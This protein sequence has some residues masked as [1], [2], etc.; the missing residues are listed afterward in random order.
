MSMETLTSAADRGGLRELTDDE[1]LARFRAFPPGSQ[2][3]AA[4]C[5]ILVERYQKLVRACV[6]QYAGSPEPVEDLLQ[7][8]VF[9]QTQG[10]GEPRLPV[11]G[12]DHDGR[13]TVPAHRRFGE[14]Q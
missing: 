14:V 10:P 7:A 13:T 4:A 1:L 6:R 5:E 11:V 2:Q 12:I 8:G 3:R 9:L